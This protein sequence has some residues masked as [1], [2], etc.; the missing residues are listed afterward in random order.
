MTGNH[1]NTDVYEQITHSIVTAI[2]Q[3]A[4]RYQMPWHTL[5]TPINAATQKPYRGVNVLNLWIASSRLGY[6]SSAWATYRQWSE[7]GAQVRRSERSTTVIFWKF[8]DREAG[9]SDAPSDPEAIESTNHHARCFARAYNLFNAAQVDG[10]QPSSSARLSEEQRL[11]N[12][13]TFFAAL[14][15]TVDFGGD[16]AFYCPSSDSIQIPPFAQFKS[17]AKFYSVLAHERCH[18]TG[19]PSRLNR[20]LSGRFGEESYTSVVSLPIGP[21]WPIAPAVLAA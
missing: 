10:Y 14:P 12:A 8:F 15:G 13:E 1:K 9:E 17:S 16:K 7:L 18:W 4:G 6:S 5:S 2:E 21:V 11:Q 19:A 20:D 3:G